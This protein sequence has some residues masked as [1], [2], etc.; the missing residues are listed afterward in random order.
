MAGGKAERI[1][2]Y[3]S[4]AGYFFLSFPTFFDAFAGLEQ[5]GGT[6]PLEKRASSA[7][8]HAQR[9]PPRSSSYSKHA[10]SCTDWLLSSPA[11]E[12]Y[13]GRRR[14]ASQIKCASLT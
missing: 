1:P 13:L 7:T 6:Q 3:E 14:A 12:K 8:L 11:A 2:E 5:R 4:E 9:A 10:S